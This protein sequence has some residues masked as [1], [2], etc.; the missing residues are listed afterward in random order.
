MQII[1]ENLARTVLSGNGYENSIQFFNL[2]HFQ[3]ILT[4]SILLND[5]TN[6]R[7]VFDY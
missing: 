4:C 5:S 1:Y 6:H 3:K 2:I 7:K